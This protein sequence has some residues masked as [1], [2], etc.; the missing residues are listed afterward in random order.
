MQQLN[1]QV[2]EKDEQINQVQTDNE[3][4]LK[5][6]MEAVEREK[7]VKDQIEEQMKKLMGQLEGV[8]SEYENQKTMTKQ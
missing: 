1:D 6:Q 7:Q 2:K 4:K 8:Q 3:R 5:E